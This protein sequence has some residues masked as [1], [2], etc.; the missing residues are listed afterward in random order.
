MMYFI[1]YAI[2]CN[3]GRVRKVNQDNFWCNGLYL[4]E[5]NDGLPFI[6]SNTLYSGDNPAIAVFDGMGGEQKG[7]SAAYIAASTFNE[8]MKD[9][10]APKG[11]SRLVSYCRTINDEISAFGNSAGISNIGSTGAL[12]SFSNKRISIANIGDSPIIRLGKNDFSQISHDHVLMP[13]RK[14]SPLTQYLGVPKSEFIIE[15]YTRELEVCH[16]D[17]YLLCSDGI[18]D[19]VS[20]DEI[21]MIMKDTK[22]IAEAAKKLLERA[23]EL[24]GVDNSTLVLCEIQKIKLFGRNGV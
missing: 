16:G 17:R 2:G 20:R 24:G 13:D 14:K 1:K 7:E 10:V 21:K 6:L 8:L 3:T 23:L 5:I 15:P 12:I 19:M 22:D 4:E 18:T 11:V 9:N